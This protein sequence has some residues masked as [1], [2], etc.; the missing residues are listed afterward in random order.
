VP[1]YCIITYNTYMHAY[2]VQGQSDRAL[3]LSTSVHG[4]APA[5]TGACGHFSPCYDP[6]ATWE[7]CGNDGFFECL[8]HSLTGRPECADEMAA[9]E[10]SGYVH[11]CA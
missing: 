11:V 8:R 5:H 3:H 7:A 9:A 1:L 10:A 2:R 4:N 6:D